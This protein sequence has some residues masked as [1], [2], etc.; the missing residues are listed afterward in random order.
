[1]HDVIIKVIIIIIIA[2]IISQNRIELY[3]F[4]MICKSR[5]YE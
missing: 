1:M 2:L 3:F 4:I 5:H